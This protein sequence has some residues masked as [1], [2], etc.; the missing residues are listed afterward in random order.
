M[1]SQGNLWKPYWPELTRLKSSINLSLFSTF[2]EVLL[3]TTSSRNETLLAYI[4]VVS[5][6][7]TN[8]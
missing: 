4:N 5:E 8:T 7:F 3:V 2:G 6:I 1:S